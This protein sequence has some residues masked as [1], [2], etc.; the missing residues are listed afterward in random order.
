[1]DNKEN[2]SMKG[3][4]TELTITKQPSSLGFLFDKAM[5]KNGSLLYISRYVSSEG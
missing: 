4:K 3:I 1:M 5:K 2:S